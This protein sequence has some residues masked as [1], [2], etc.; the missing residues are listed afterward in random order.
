MVESWI[1]TD[2]KPFA[3][4][5]EFYKILPPQDRMWAQQQHFEQLLPILATVANTGLI[6]AVPQPPSQ[7]DLHQPIQGGG[8]GTHTTQTCSN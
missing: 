6:P 8:E 1:N 4:R 2:T 5:G 7:G 3:P